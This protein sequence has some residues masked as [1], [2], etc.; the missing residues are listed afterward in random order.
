MVEMSVTSE[1]THT[2]FEATAPTAPTAGAASERALP[3]SVRPMI[4]ATGPVMEAGR[5]FSTA[6]RPQKRTSRPAA[7]D[8]RPDSTMPNCAC[9]ISAAGRMPVASNWA[10][11]SAVP[12]AATML[13][14]AVRYA[15]LEP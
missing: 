11:C 14:M 1:T 9:E 10:I 4:M 13:E 2:Q 6:R 12:S 15:K 7:M 3:A 5:I 8:T